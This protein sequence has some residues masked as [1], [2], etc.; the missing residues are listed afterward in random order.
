MVQLI[1][2]KMRIRY[3]GT[4]MPMEWKAGI[5]YIDIMPAS[6]Y[7]PR[8]EFNLSQFQSG[9]LFFLKDIY[10]YLSWSCGGITPHMSRSLQMVESGTGSP[11]AI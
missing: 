10:F 8:K 5:A 3:H 7:L 6:P 2:I 1:K 11:G 9:T 4:S